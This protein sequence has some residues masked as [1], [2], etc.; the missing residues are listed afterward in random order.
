MDA[1]DKKVLNIIQ[2]HFPLERRPYA[3]VGQQLGLTECEVL[4]RVRALMARG[5]IRRIGANFQSKAIGWQSTLCAAS[6]PPDKL[7]T[8]VAEVNVHPGVTHNYVRDHQYNVWFTFIG[9]TWEQVCAAL[10]DITA[11]TGIPILNLPARRMFKIKVDFQ[12]PEEDTRASTCATGQDA[13]PAEA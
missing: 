5:I 3:S 2:S 11:R 6:V 10:A 13:E 9:P 12:M 7:E 8:F 1:I 4:A